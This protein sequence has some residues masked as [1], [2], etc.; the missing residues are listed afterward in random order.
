MGPKA[1]IFAPISHDF[2]LL[3][4]RPAQYDGNFFFTSSP[5]LGA[6]QSPISSCKTLLFVNLPTTIIIVFNKT[7]FINKNILE[8]INKFISSNQTNFKQKLNNIIKVFNK[9]ISQ[10]KQK[11][12]NTKSMIQ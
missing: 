3:H 11:S 4:S 5:S 1:R 6:L 9:A 2:V 10:Q 7:Y 12:Y 8:I